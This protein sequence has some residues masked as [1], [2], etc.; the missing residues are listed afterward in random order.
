MDM[1][2]RLKRDILVNMADWV[3]HPASYFHVIFKPP[4]GH[5]LGGFYVENY[6]PASDDHRHRIKV[7]A[8]LSP[9]YMPHR[10][11]LAYREPLENDRYLFPFDYKDELELLLDYMAHR[12][13]FVLHNSHPNNFYNTFSGSLD[14]TSHTSSLDIGVA[15]TACFLRTNNYRGVLQRVISK[16]ENTRWTPTESSSDNYNTYNEENNRY[17]QENDEIIQCELRPLRELEEAIAGPSEAADLFFKG[18]RKQSIEGWT[19]GEWAQA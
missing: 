9:L 11:D 13:T 4:V 1:L 7:G 15:Y 5:I 12:Q 19:L 16:I 3:A 18:I 14:K 6:G 17:D 8:F 10:G 2:T